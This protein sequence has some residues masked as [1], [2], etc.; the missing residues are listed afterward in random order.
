MDELLDLIRSKSKLSDVGREL[1]LY[2]SMWADTAQA[3]LAAGGAPVI[4]PVFISGTG[5]TAS[6]FFHAAMRD[7]GFR[8]A[9]VQ[10]AT[11]LVSAEDADDILVRAVDTY[12][13]MGDE[14][15]PE[16][17]MINPHQWDDPAE[18]IHFDRSAWLPGWWLP[19]YGG[20]FEWS[21]V[22][23]FADPSQQYQHLRRCAEVLSVGGERWCFRSPV[24]L[25]HLPALYAEFP[26]AIVVWLERDSEQVEPGLRK[27]IYS[28][29]RTR[30]RE[31]DE[32]EV[33]MLANSQATLSPMIAQAA[34]DSG[35]VPLDQLIRVQF[36][37]ITENV[38]VTVSNVMQRV[39]DVTLRFDPQ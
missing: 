17:A 6:S 15:A 30:S 4:A 36:E 8:V 18:D 1:L 39:S 33:A 31:V 21:T 14:E 10:E 27:M 28:M 23:M 2:D 20:T 25:L 29:R 38:D 26:D 24:H 12:I 16:Y 13:R 22:R 11:T 7:V 34:V 5:R 37:D 32:D 35:A 19:H 9:T 3:R